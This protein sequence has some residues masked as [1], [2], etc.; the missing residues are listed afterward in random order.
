MHSGTWTPV[1]ID[2]TYSDAH[3]LT[4]ADMSGN[5]KLDIVI[6]EMEQAPNKRVSV[7]YNV[8]GDG[9]RGWRQQVL[10]TTGEQNIRVGDIN[11]DGNL[12]IFGCNHGYLA[13][14]TLPEIWFSA[15]PKIADRPAPPSELFVFAYSPTQNTLSWTD[16]SKVLSGYK[17]ALGFSIERSID[18][19]HFMPIGAAG[20]S[21]SLYADKTAVPGKTYFYRVRSINAA[22]GSRYSRVATLVQGNNVR[23]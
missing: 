23:S 22:G 15:L 16:N 9:P 14:P 17:A 4:L 5:G 13:A 8:G 21:V 2:P 11:G 19:Q 3:K 7:F 10:A 1:V 18:N 6:A 20:E 12:D